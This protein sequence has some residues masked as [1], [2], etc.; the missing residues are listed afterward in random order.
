MGSEVRLMDKSQCIAFL[1]KP[2]W[3]WVLDDGVKQ[4]A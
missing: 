1:K 2:G 4:N 3:W